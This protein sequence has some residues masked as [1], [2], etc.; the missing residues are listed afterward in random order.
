MLISDSAHIYQQYPFFNRR[1]NDVLVLLTSGLINSIVRR[2]VTEW[3][4]SNDGRS[5]FEGMIN[6]LQGPQTCEDLGLN[7]A[8]LLCYRRLRGVQDTPRT[9][10]GS[11]LLDFDALLNFKP[12]Y[13]E[14]ATLEQMMLSFLRVLKTFKGR[15]QDLH[16]FLTA[17][18][19]MEDTPV[20]HPLDGYSD[21]Y[22]NRRIEYRPGHDGAFEKAKLQALMK[23]I[24]LNPVETGTDDDND[25]ETVSLVGKTEKLGIK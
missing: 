15:F 25:W 1:E 8:A 17:T 13:N 20:L 24:D 7:L 23:F 2:V 19:G 5:T 6:N 16:R 21:Q 12:L 18:L 9:T 22:F 4:L 3:S 11:Y 14:Q 10:N